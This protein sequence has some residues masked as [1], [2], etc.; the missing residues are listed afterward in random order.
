M[1]TPKMN[2]MSVAMVENMVMNFDIC[3]LS[4]WDENDS[5]YAFCA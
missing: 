5:G 4:G 3:R 2:R 1:I